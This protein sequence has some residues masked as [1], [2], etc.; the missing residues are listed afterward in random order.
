[1]DRMRHA[2]CALALIML[3][4]AAAAA[5]PPAPAARVPAAGPRPLVTRVP[6]PMAPPRVAPAVPRPQ[7][8]AVITGGGRLPAKGRPVVGR[9]PG[10]VA[11]ARMALGERITLRAPATPRAPS[12]PAATR[13][14]AGDAL[15]SVIFGPDAGDGGWDGPVFDQ[16]GGGFSDPADLPGRRPLLSP[17]GSALPV[18]PSPLQNLAEGLPDRLPDIEDPV[19][20]EPFAL[21]PLDRLGIYVRALSAGE[22]RDSTSGRALISDL[23]QA[24]PAP[25]R[26]D[27]AANRLLRSAVLDV[28][29]DYEQLFGAAPVEAAPQDAPEEQARRIRAAIS[30][31]W[32]AFG[33]QGEQ[34]LDA[35]AWRLFLQASPEHAA[36]LDYLAGLAR[37]FQRLDITG[38][39]PAELRTARSALLG[40]ITPAGASQQELE[41]MI[42]AMAGG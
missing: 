33:R 35:P 7:A 23:P 42:G 38:L 37:L 19:K 4:E 14:G 30:G 27:V 20:P 31:A 41:R 22:L 15:A 16:D 21:R 28:V 10:A 26:H 1:M 3:A 25:P 17:T 13:F 8:P 5:R 29:R 40:P 32:E 2:S 36:A 18:A 6:P 34:P 39:T 9:A 12:S 11:S 24:R